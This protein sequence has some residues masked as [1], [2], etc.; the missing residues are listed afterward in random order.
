MLIMEIRHFYLKNVLRWGP[1]YLGFKLYSALRNFE[2][3]HLWDL[4]ALFSNIFCNVISN[5]SR[6]L[7]LTQLSNSFHWKIIHLGKNYIDS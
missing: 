4:I 3:L 5:S 7:E 1:V 2:V 6:G